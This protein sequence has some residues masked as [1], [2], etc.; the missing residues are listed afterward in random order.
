MNQ[1]PFSGK[2]MPALKTKQAFFWLAVCLIL[3]TGCGRA[4]AV[5][6]EPTAAGASSIVISTFTAAPTVLPP[7][8][9][10]SIEPTSD[11]AANGQIPGLSPRNVTVALEDQNFTCTE[12]TKGSVYYERTCSRGVPGAEV[13]LVVISGRTPSVVD[14]IEGLILQYEN[15][16]NEIAIQILNLVAGLPYDGATPDEARAWVES[17]IPALSGEPGGEQEAMFGGV[18]YVLFGPPTALTLEI[19][20]LP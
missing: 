6:P 14:F 19:G 5:T 1:H 15:P 8:P 2:P 9:E 20:E 18:K 3:L 12:V 10:P 13:F 17:T 4:P 7:S 16:E 11:A